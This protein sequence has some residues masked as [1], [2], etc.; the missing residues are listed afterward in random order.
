MVEFLLGHSSN[1]GL[2]DLK[3]CVLIVQGLVFHHHHIVKSIVAMDDR[4]L[5]EVGANVKNNPVFG[6]AK[7]LQQREEV[8]EGVRLVPHLGGHHH[9][10]RRGGDGE[11]EDEDDDGVDNDSPEWRRKQKVV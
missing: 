2:Q 9:H 3:T 8:G 6:K 4:H 7:L 1:P 10:S 5:I 11:Q